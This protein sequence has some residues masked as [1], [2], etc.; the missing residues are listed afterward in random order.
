MAW[1]AK[2]YRINLIRNLRDKERRV[3]KRRRLRIL[4]SLACFALLVLA[5]AYSGFTM[6]DMEKVLATEQNKLNQIKFEYNKYTA[7]RTIVDKGDV[8]LLNALQGRGILWTKK[9]A[10]LAMHLPDN[11]AITGFSYRV[12]ELR[13]TG[14]GYVNSKQD[15]LLVLDWY[16]NRLRQDTVFSNVFKQLHLNRAERSEEAE[17][18][19]VTFDFSAINPAAQGPK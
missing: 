3:E 12:G 9:L 7:A 6:M 2:S 4:A 19:R 8:E 16:L 10:S 5:F 18:G 11:Y 15:Q 14:F 17:A 13:V 1:A